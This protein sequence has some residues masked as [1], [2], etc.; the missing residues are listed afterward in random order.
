M[1]KTILAIMLSMCVTAYAQ[2][3]SSDLQQ[4]SGEILGELSIPSIKLKQ[5]VREG[6]NMS[7]IDLGVAHW[8]GT[9][10]PGENGNVVF[11]GHRST[12]TAPFFRIESVRVG[13][14]ILFIRDRIA[15]EYVVYDMFVVDRKKMDIIYRPVD[16]LDG[17]LTI[18]TCHPI[19]FSTKR[20]VVRARL[21]SHKTP[22]SM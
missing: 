2:L 6:V 9:A 10:R 11:A 21:S 22:S 5:V 13:D 17:I 15:M 3:P 20:F 1:R 18:F 8:A 12:K 4:K 16:P 14:Q 19:H 7:I